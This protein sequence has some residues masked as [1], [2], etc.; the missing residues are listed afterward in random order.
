MTKL[1][2]Q[3]NRFCLSSEDLYVK[4]VCA[5]A[6][7][8]GKWLTLVNNL[9]YWIKYL[10]NFKADELALEIKNAETARQISNTNNDKGMKTIQEKCKDISAAIDELKSYSGSV[11]MSSIVL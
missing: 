5:N 11:V 1:L 10:M 8:S 9:L 2:Y 6:K 4:M 7:I 3:R